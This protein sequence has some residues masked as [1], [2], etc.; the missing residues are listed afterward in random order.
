MNAMVEAA[1]RR[2]VGVYPIASHAIRPVPVQGVMLGYGLVDV[3]R[4]AE[5]V[6]GF[7]VA[8]RQVIATTTPRSSRK[9][10][11]SRASR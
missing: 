2:G 5:G 1:Q 9:R 4:I 10:E 6:R 11:K 8:Y 7:A 3:D